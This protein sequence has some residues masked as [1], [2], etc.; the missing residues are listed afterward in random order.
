MKRVLVAD[1]A[2]RGRGRIQ[3]GCP[4]LAVGAGELLAKLADLGGE[5]T[6]ARVR[7]FQPAQQARV[8]GA[9]G[10]RYGAAGGRPV[11]GSEA[12]DRAADGGFGV[13]PGAAA[14]RVGT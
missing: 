11:R 2:G 13:E 1:L 12:L 4:E 6:V 3:P 5:L 8:A 9:L 14:R 7:G 10:R